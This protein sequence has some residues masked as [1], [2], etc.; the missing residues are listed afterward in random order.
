MPRQPDQPFPP[1]ADLTTEG[2]ALWSAVLAEMTEDELE[3]TAQE[4]RYLL[5]ACREADVIASI[6]AAFSGEPHVVKGS[7]GQPVAHPLLAELRQHRATLSQLLARVKTTEPAAAEPHRR[8]ER[9]QRTMGQ[10]RCL[11]AE[12]GTGPA[13]PSP[14]SGTGSSPTTNATTP[15][16]VPAGGASPAAHA[17]S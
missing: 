16:G 7:Q 12:A 13:A 9:R 14:A 2:S 15:H 6:A 17:P 1:P 4:R 11:D 5:D 3:P 10:P 8:P